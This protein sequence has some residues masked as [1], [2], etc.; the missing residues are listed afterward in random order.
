MRILSIVA[1][2]SLSLTGALQAGPL[3]PAHIG[4]DS[5]WVVHV[6]IEAIRAIPPVKEMHEKFLQKD[7]VQAK[8]QEISTMLGMNPTQD[9]FGVTAYSTGYE[10]HKGVALVYVRKA[11]REK[12]VAL[13]KQKHPDHKT[14]QHGDRTVYSW[15]EKHR[16]CE[17]ELS[18]TFA[19]DGI[20][21][22]GS[23]TDHVHAALDVIDGKRPAT[24][25]DAASVSGATS[26]D[27]V[28]IR[29]M[30]IPEELTK[31]AKAKV[32]LNISGGTAQW[33]FADN[34]LSAHYDVIART[35]ETAQALK[36][37]V[38]GVKAGG[39]LR[40][41]DLAD[42]L[43]VVNALSTAVENQTLTVDFSSS[44][45]EI[46]AGVEQAIKHHKEQRN[47]N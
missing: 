42:V 20:I 30:D 28:F 37:V 22:I 6:N 18:G 46:K 7:R 1:A 14:T 32:A 19:G 33:Q 4:A 43:K 5:K 12:L 35:A 2:I 24:A 44:L 25:A 40:Y 34:R 16:G 8:V 41:Q 23:G 29:A 45:D 47:K 3:N 39:T 17:I 27:L 13:F 15:T 38:D 11:D 21:L 36:A 31:K 9:I 26:N 10:E